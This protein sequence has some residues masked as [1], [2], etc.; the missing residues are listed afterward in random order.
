MDFLD[1]VFNKDDKNLQP[2]EKV[3]KKFEPTVNVTNKVIKLNYVIYQILRK[4]LANL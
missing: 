2:V 3:K 1:F 4:W